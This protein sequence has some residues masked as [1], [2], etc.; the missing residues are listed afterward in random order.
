MSK[1]DIKYPGP[2]DFVHL[3]TH[4]IFSPLDGIASP[5]DYMKR[6]VELGMP[7]VA[8]T[9]HGSMASFPDAFF[10]SQK[11]GVKFIP[12]CET[13]YN[14]LHPDL[15]KFQEAKDQG[16]MT[17]QALKEKDLE[18]WERLRRQ[19]HVT[20]LAK[21]HEGYKNL[22]EMVSAAWEIGFYYKPRIWMDRLDKHREGLIVLSGCLNGPL[23]HE[24]MGANE[25][26][27]AGDHKKSTRL[28]KMARKWL[29]EIHEIFGD[30]LYVEMQMP[31]EDLLGSTNAFWIA[32]KW[33]DKYK[34]KSVIT[35]DCHYIKKED[36]EVQRCM[37]AVDQNLT[38]DD[39]GLFIVNS[40]E[41]Y[42][43]TRADLRQSFKDQEYSKHVSIE[44]FEESC[45]NTLDVA[46]KCE[47]FT[48][49]LSP[50]LPIIENANKKLAALVYERLREKNLFN[51]KSTYLIDGFRVTHKQQAEIE[52]KRIISKGFASY[53]LIT[54]ELVQYSL[55]N[56]WDVGPAR[57]S[58]GGSL[59]CYL[60]GIHELN[61][62]KWDLS[63]NRF[64][65]PSRGGFL[66]N[67]SLE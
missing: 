44:K 16:G 27:K 43:K 65:S 54:M 66:L 26:Q 48:P 23:N 59:V 17:W 45:D 55:D 33:S 15:K 9:D 62:L 5:E 21:N 13:Y 58:A 31:G 20:V 28:L 18:R 12:G 51:D 14:D 1:Q 6:C 32:A 56:E 38:I 37:M 60:L 52:L 29:L 46:N 30:D 3:H 22:I 67:V 41:Q 35:N 2:K 8:I 53:F 63:F 19:R 42:F 64:M 47:G 36:F 7:A 24:I 4:T 61:P 39:P 50:K 57:G 25:A 10:A 11:H 49:D 34:I 40:N